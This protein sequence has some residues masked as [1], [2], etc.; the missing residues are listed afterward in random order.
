[1]NT[2]TATRKPTATDAYMAHH[3]A[4]VA[5]L[6]RI[7]DALPN[8]DTA[9]AEGLHW[10]HVGD[11]AETRKT[12]QELSDRLFNEGE[13][14]TVACTRCSATFAHDDPAFRTHSFNAHR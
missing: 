14:A 4:T 5:L 11:A 2:S 12:L 3:E 10:G 13:Y 7:T 1:M 9:P 6:A 8:H